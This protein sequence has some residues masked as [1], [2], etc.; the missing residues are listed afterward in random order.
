MKC[1]EKVY[2]LSEALKELYSSKLNDAQ[3]NIIKTAW[4]EVH[5]DTSTLTPNMSVY[6]YDDDDDD[7][8][9][10]EY[11]EEN[12]DDNDDDDNDNDDDDD[13][14]DN[15]DDD[16]DDDLETE[17]SVDDEDDDGYGGDD[18]D[19]DDDNDAY[20]KYK[21]A[22]VLRYV[23]NKSFKDIGTMF[24][25]TSERA[26]QIVKKAEALVRDGTIRA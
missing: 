22:L 20:S 9:E 8:M 5:G 17:L 4:L 24:N 18:D 10:E 6:E 13:D 16:D 7:G 2:I 12:D 1:L 26:R 15:D 11:Y 19:D 25:V 3:A 21:A 14:D 23:E